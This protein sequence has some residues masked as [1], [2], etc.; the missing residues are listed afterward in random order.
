MVHKPNSQEK[1]QMTNT[2]NSNLS[3][4]NLYFDS[5][6]L[7]E[8]QGI[9]TPVKESLVIEPKD[10]TLEL[11]NQLS[12]LAQYTERGFRLLP[13]SLLGI[14]SPLTAN[15]FSINRVVARFDGTG[16]V[17]PGTTSLYQAGYK[18]Q[19]KVQ[20]P[21]DHPF[22]A[23]GKRTQFIGNGF[24][25]EIHLTEDGWSFNEDTAI[26]SHHY[27][28]E[29]LIL[30]AKWAAED[31]LA[32][33]RRGLTHEYNITPDIRE[34]CE[35][36]ISGKILHATRNKELI[37]L[38][39]YGEMRLLNQFTYSYADFGLSKE[40]HTTV[41]Q[42]AVI[43]NEIRK[44]ISARMATI[45]GNSMVAEGE[46]AEFLVFSFPNAF[47]YNAPKDGYP[48]PFINMSH[49]WN[50]ETY[51]PGG[52][53]IMARPV[54]TNKGKAHKSLPLTNRKNR[55]F[56]QRPTETTPLPSFD[57]PEKAVYNLT[58]PSS[59][60]SPSELTP[61]GEDFV[62]APGFLDDLDEQYT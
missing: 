59:P 1:T 16:A 23:A 58:V 45:A 18:D 40:Q 54:T 48:E 42:S 53:L 38:A 39:A 2:N 20:F 3:L 57:T 29:N 49:Y 52:L 8:A 17:M 9:D 46:Y 32:G 14:S 60:I 26:V 15:G 10:F 44:V 62:E 30:K 34:S 37:K 5:S 13:E 50:Q 24:L 36:I 47:G 31:I 28:E 22:G 27:S 51:L 41:G 25:A 35:K 21:S 6:V 43:H 4:D 11:F 12:P 33:V 19:S 55:Y 56:K 61:S 7:F